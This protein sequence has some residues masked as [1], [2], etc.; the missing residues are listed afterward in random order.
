[1]TPTTKAHTVLDWV[2]QFMAGVI[3]VAGI[4]TAAVTVL[5]VPAYQWDDPYARFP[6]EMDYDRSL[7]SLGTMYPPDADLPRGTSLELDDTQVVLTYPRPSRALM[8]LSLVPTMFIGLCTLATAW[9]L[10][11]VLRDVGRGHPFGRGSLRRLLGLT[12]LVPIGLMSYDLLV[13]VGAS[14]ALDS[15][16]VEEGPLSA[17]PVQLLAPLCV[18]F[19]LVALTAAFMRGRE[20]HNDVAGMV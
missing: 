15:L 7:L 13:A 19:L 14:T 4:A 1:V 3:L 20:L 16:G 10:F 8:L 5:M 12:L 2:L 11:G 18:A 9:L 6:V 17:P